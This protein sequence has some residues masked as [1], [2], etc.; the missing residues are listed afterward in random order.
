MDNSAQEKNPSAEDRD[1]KA[2]RR[3]PAH[4]YVLLFF[5]AGASIA[6]LLLFRI[7]EA[8]RANPLTVI[9]QDTSGLI[10]IDLMALQGENPVEVY[11][12]WKNT[13]I[14]RDLRKKAEHDLSFDLDEDFLSWVGPRIGITF[15]SGVIPGRDGF[16]GILAVAT[17]RDRKEMKDAIER[18]RKKNNLTY[19]EKKVQGVTIFVPQGK[20]QPFFCLFRDFFLLSDNPETIEKSIT[21]VLQKKKTLLDD[22]GYRQTCASLPSSRMVTMYF[23]RQGN[24]VTD[25]HSPLEILQ[26]FGV[27]IVRKKEGTLLSGLATLDSGQKTI[28]FEESGYSFVSP[29]YTPGD[30]PCFLALNMRYRSIIARLLTAVQK[31]N[32]LSLDTLRL[33]LQPVAGKILQ[34]HMNSE[35]SIALDLNGIINT[36]LKGARI[37]SLEQIPAVITIRVKDR[38]ESENMQKLLSGGKNPDDTYKNHALFLINSMVYTFVENYLVVSTDGDRKALHRIIDTA[39]KASSS[40][41]EDSCHRIISERALKNDLLFIRLSLSEVALPLKIYAAV[42]PDM[43]GIAW[44]AKNYSEIWLHAGAEENRIRIDLFLKGNQP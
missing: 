27:S 24:A 28:R 34:S 15:E 19:Q 36:A 26:S 2:K 7:Y 42:N 39:L 35:V 4:L 31:D 6:A 25:T 20:N 44:L 14:Y 21:T 5:L 8:P 23:V 11:G 32:R 41:T 12:K 16:R 17:I 30:T 9:P 18:I 33:K 10:F 29:S 1:K 37:D 3:L 22:P 13:D 40:L 43:K 38:Q